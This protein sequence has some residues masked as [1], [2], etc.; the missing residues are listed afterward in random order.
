M[1]KI[2]KI[3]IKKKLKTGQKILELEKSKILSSHSSFVSSIARKVDRDAYAL[4]MANEW[5]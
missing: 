2:K 4:R 1:I 5:S 3:S